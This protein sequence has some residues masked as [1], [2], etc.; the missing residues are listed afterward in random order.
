MRILSLAILAAFASTAAQAIT[1]V[2]GD[3]NSTSTG[4]AGFAGNVPGWS[5]GGNL[6]F[7]D[8]PGTA[9]DGSYLSV[10]GPFP[11]TSPVGGWFVEADGDGP[12]RDNIFQT[13]SG[14]T[15]GQSYVVSFYQAAGQQVGFTG[16][17]T[18]RW[19][20]SFGGTTQA[21]STF[22][23]PEGGVGPWQKQSLTFVADAT[24]LVLNFLADGTPGGAP[25][26]SFL[27][28]VTVDAVAT[29]E[30]AA[31]ALFGLGLAGLAF[32]RRAR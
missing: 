26:I 18:E 23:L 17:T 27:D 25:P 1:V 20:V 11:A 19:L 8:A 28:G 2:N 7:I 9:D 12:F 32:R 30:P 22:S 29:P 10:Y 31:L 5:G 24:S 16:P 6:T 13:I 21:S 3:F 4:K 15:V 14:L